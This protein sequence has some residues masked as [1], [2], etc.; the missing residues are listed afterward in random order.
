MSTTTSKR[1]VSIPARPR[2]RRSA[3]RSSELLDLSPST[4]FFMSHGHHQ[5]RLSSLTP[6]IQTSLKDHQ[7][8][9]SISSSLE[10]FTLT[11]LNGLEELDY[12][13]CSQKKKHC[14]FINNVRFDALEGVMNWK[15]SKHDASD[16]YLKSA[17][18]GVRWDRDKNQRYCGKWFHPPVMAL[19]A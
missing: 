3:K 12:M 17:Q 13:F 5:G 15:C 19:M 7:L 9:E 18:W 6:K 14:S 4:S 2:N 16:H 10:G 8:K 11:R 1:R